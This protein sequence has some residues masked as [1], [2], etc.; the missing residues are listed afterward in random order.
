M[1]REEAAALLGVGSLSTS[2]EVRAAYRAQ[3]RNR[4]PDRAGARGTADAARLNEAYALLRRSAPMRPEST[5]PEVPVPEVE[6]LDDDTLA[7]AIP[8]EE[9]FLLLLNTAHD[10]GE[11]TYVDPDAGLIETIVTFA[12][13]DL[14]ACSVVLSLQGRAD[15]VEAFCSVESLQGSDPPPVSEVVALLA[16]GVRKRL[17]QRSVR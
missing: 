5:D 1:N 8:V 16:S 15:R 9:V 14:P 11:V 13:P 10:V 12:G 3:I 6:V 7:L 17:Q 4:H 2:D